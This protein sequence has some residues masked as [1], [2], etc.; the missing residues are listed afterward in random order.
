V[1]RYR[2]YGLILKSDV[3]LPELVP[4]LRTDRGTRPDVTVRLA[5]RRRER[6]PINQFL[7]ETQLPGG[8]LGRK[9]WRTDEGFAIVFPGLARFDLSAGGDRVGCTRRSDGVAIRTI[10][11]L[12]L[13]QLMPLLLS[14]RGREALHATAIATG[15]GVCAFIG[16]AG[17]GKS[18]IAGAFCRAGFIS[19]ADDC[20]SLFDRGAIA[21]VPAY[22]GL[23]LWNDTAT[24]LGIE[25]DS[26]PT[27]AHYTPKRRAFPLANPR[28][29]PLAPIPLARI[30]RLERSDDAG[31]SS[32]SV[33]IESIS[34]RDALLEL[35]QASFPLDITDQQTLER[36]FRFMER[37]V[38]MV[39]IS[40]LVIPLGF[41]RLDEARN[42]VL[43]DLGS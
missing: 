29:F 20:L 6:S 31:A 23:R 8:E 37:V 43:A 40:R 2:A 5:R 39:P 10:R 24:A 14:L 32:T 42:A 34:P 3:P 13:D 1:Y 19:L 41:D 36:H 16:P 4:A 21:A 12:L 27:V 11:H 35:V 18:T 30:Y 15:A 33:H 7:A 38:E 25:D 28:D 26:G 17:T 9:I 22:P